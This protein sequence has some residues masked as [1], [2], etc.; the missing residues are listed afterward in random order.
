[1]IRLLQ[2]NSLFLSQICLLDS[3]FFFYF[4]S[5]NLLLRFIE[6]LWTFYISLSFIEAS[7]QRSF[8]FKRL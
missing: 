1:M 5:F 2:I 3:I 8:F 7:K 6:C 4:L